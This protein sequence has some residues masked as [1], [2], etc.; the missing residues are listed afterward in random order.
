VEIDTDE[1][2][3]QQN[4]RLILNSVSF[5]PFRRDQSPLIKKYPT[6]MQIE[7]D[8]CKLAEFTRGIRTYTSREGM[9]IVPKF[10]KKYGM[11]V[12][13]SA[14]LGTKL[15]TNELEIEALIK[16]ANTHSTTIERVIVGNE[17]LLRGDLKVD[18][19]I[20]YIRRIKAA[21]KQPVSYAD[22]WAFYLKYPEVGRE[23]DYITIHILP[24][25]ENKPI[26]IED[27]EEHFLKIIDLIRKTFPDK[28]ILIGET[29]WPSFGRNRG[30]SIVSTINEARFIRYVAAIAKRHGFDYN[31][32][33]AFDQPWKVALEG[34]V[35]SSWGIFDV[36]RKAKFEMKGPVV[37]IANWSLRACWSI[38]IGIMLGLIFGL[39]VSSFVGKLS[40]ATISQILSWLMVTTIFHVE[41]C[42][43][44]WWQ[45]I[46]AIFRCG[47][48]V[49]ITM[50]SIAYCANFLVNKNVIFINYVYSNLIRFIGWYAIA[51]NI[52][53]IFD[54]R[55]RDI[56]VIDFS[57]PVVGLVHMFILHS[58]F[59][60][61]QEKSILN[62]FACGNLFNNNTTL[63]HTICLGV[64]L[65]LSAVMV[66][67]SEGLVVT[68][69]LIDPLALGNRIFWI[70]N[71]EMNLWSIMILIL[72]IPYVS[73]S[74]LRRRARLV[75]GKTSY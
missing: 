75:L 62:V 37:E 49:V 72:A 16:A 47:I 11:K 18:Q 26:A 4:E 14:W 60:Y 63:R 50:V 27:T 19:L 43:F 55:Y 39:N 25:W 45:N 65:L 71:R 29:G 17:V 23:V 61:R 35:G 2:L 12:I 42:S 5:A 15:N 66:I 58:F 70:F 21:I 10:A 33:E 73:S 32:V 51:W 59:R 57:V 74:I 6:S 68:D 64:C 31:I 67:I 41:A 46:L 1:L 30:A 53:L 40:I 24:F 38:S 48:S 54:G 52:L 36:D 20:S 34:T 8:L 9:E 7:E 13:F 22:V 69:E 3:K 28:K 44:Y 56:P